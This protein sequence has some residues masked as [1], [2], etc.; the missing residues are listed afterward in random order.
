MGAETTTGRVDITDESGRLV[1]HG[2]LRLQN[3]DGQS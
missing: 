1:A 2:D 3:V